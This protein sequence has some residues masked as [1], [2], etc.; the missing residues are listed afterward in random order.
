MRKQFLNLED[1]YVCNWY[2]TT[3][4]NPMRMLPPKMRRGISV[5]KVE[6]LVVAN[7]IVAELGDTRNYKYSKQIMKMAGY[8]LSWA[9]K[10]WEINLS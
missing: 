10:V 3:K 8:R 9:K 7:G 5:G 2:G 1:D 6:K 4:W